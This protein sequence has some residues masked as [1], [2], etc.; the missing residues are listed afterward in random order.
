M[1][2]TTANYGQPPPQKPADGNKERSKGPEDWTGDRQTLAA[3]LEPLG[4]EQTPGCP[5]PT[6]P[7]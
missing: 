3:G 4:V 5:L 2:C 1:A 6:V 7:L